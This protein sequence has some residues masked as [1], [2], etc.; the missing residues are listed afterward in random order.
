MIVNEKQD[1]GVLKC[2]E[3]IYENEAGVELVY[4]Q[5]DG[6]VKIR[7]H[8]K[9]EK[10]LSKGIKKTD[11]KE[12]VKYAQNLGET[13]QPVP[14]VIEWKQR[15]KNRALGR[16]VVFADPIESDT[17]VAVH[18]ESI[19]EGKKRRLEELEVTHEF[20]DSLK[21]IKEV[22]ENKEVKAI[23]I[24]GDGEV[25]IGNGKKEDHI[26]KISNLQKN[27]IAMKAIRVSNYINDNM[28]GITFRNSLVVKLP[29]VYIGADKAQKI[30]VEVECVF[31]ASGRIITMNL[32][33]ALIP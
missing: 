8:E 32:N 20:L 1:N 5:K 15:M 19:E 21:D 2:I 31:T 13:R 22:L 16:V 4:I 24:N 18:F 25:W 27:N 11:I 29:E 26:G 9:E 3:M 30:A 10:I 23:K 6:K 7:E 14:G 33:K 28:S 12:F 17:V